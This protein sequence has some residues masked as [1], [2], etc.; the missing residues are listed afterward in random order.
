MRTWT[1][2]VFLLGLIAVLIAGC[3][4][5]EESD[6]EST[7]PLPNSVC[8]DG[9]PDSNPPSAFDTELKARWT[10]SVDDAVPGARWD[11]EQFM[12]AHM[13][14]TVVAMAIR[15]VPKNDTTH[16]RFVDGEA[17]LVGV[18]ATSGEVKWTRPLLRGAV[19]AREPVRGEAVCI[20]DRRSTNDT[21]CA[22]VGLEEDRPLSPCDEGVAPGV[23][24]RT[25]VSIQY[26][27][28]DSGHT[29]TEEPQG[30]DAATVDRNTLVTASSVDKN[31]IVVQRRATPYS[32]GWEST[33]ARRPQKR[34]VAA[35]GIHLLPVA[36]ARGFLS[37]WGDSDMV[38]A[39]LDAETGRRV[40]DAS[41]T[42]PYLAATALPHRQV[43]VYDAN[44]TAVHDSDGRKIRELP[45]TMVS[46]LPRSSMRSTVSA[47]PPTFVYRGVTGRDGTHDEAFDLE[48]GDRLPA[49][50]MTMSA[51]PST[52]PSQPGTA[53]G[54]VLVFVNTSG[55]E[56]TG[57]TYNYYGAMDVRSGQ[58]LWT[59]KGKFPTGEVA[60]D[61]DSTILLRASSEKQDTLRAFDVR[62]GV[63]RWETRLDPFEGYS[64]G[65]AIGN[66]TLTRMT[67]Q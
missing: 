58:V 3:S 1:E 9:R 57:L 59:A 12:P 44:T 61:G 32:H 45:R 22:Y 39:V 52:S 15:G 23:G 19:C 51:Y 29:R 63:V 28:L 2:R 41:N 33:V 38:G 16:R 20:V 17:T 50:P 5:P 49:V 6:T 11:P 55:H 7:S 43:A 64:D 30:V 27:R 37:A 46:G 8:A 10:L 26:V 54:G 31:T 42:G 18:D 25:G 21:Y 35:D 47:A 34:E 60:N 66:D 24:G 67:A 56:R 13:C 53:V 40:V 62:R 65:V 48:T 4:S 14:G 36:G